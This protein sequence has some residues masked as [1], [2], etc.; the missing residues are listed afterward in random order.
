VVVHARSFQNDNEIFVARLD[1]RK[2]EKMGS[3][4][5]SQY[6]SIPEDESDE[7]GEEAEQ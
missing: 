7:I 1:P 6:W 4:N 2:E 3:S 5:N